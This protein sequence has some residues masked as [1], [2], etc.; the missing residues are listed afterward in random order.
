MVRKSTV[1][2]YT[3]FLAIYVCA[4]VTILILFFIKGNLDVLLKDADAM[5]SMTMVQIV[6]FYLYKYFLNFPFGALNWFS[7]KRLYST[8][9]FLI[10]NSIFIGWLIAK[11]F[12]SDK[13]DIAKYMYYACL[14]FIVLNFFVLIF[15]FINGDLQKFFD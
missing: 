6:Y 4:C 13:K 14:G 10:P 9:F 3:R 7:D 8:L 5:G 15:G 1:K 2:Y 11:F 12:P